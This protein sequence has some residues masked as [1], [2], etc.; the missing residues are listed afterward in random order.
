LIDSLSP[1][2]LRLAFSSPRYTIKCFIFINIRKRARPRLLLV[3]GGS[4]NCCFS[5]AGRA[6]W[7][8]LGMSRL[9]HLH[10][11][12]LVTGNLL[13]SLSQA[14]CSH[15]PKIR[16]QRFL[17]QGDQAFQK[18]QFSAAAICYGQAIQIDPRFTETHFKLAQTRIRMSSWM[19]ACQEFRRTVEPRPKNLQGQL[20]L[21]P[22]DDI[23]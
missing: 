8:G 9:C 19:A 21:C 11:N 22:W 6:K 1:M 14:G 4:K 10:K 7:N 3:H 20:S 23:T 13:F 17:V 5:P 16:K 15:D 12:R 2:G 18:G